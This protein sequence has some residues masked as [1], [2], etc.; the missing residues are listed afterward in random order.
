ML[1]AMTTK[2]MDMAHSLLW[3]QNSV[4]CLAYAIWLLSVA[5]NWK[6]PIKI[7]GQIIYIIWGVK[8]LF[9]LNIYEGFQSLGVV[10]KHNTPKTKQ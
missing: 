8:R 7:R 2:K 6:K 10:Y 4:S 1:V 3:Q 9:S 5:I